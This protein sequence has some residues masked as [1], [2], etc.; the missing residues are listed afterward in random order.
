MSSLCASS[1]SSVWLM[2]YCNIPGT[3][4][5]KEPDKHHDDSNYQQ[6]VNEPSHGVTAHQTQ[7]P[8]NYQYYC[9]CPQ[10]RI[11]LPDCSSSLPRPAGQ[12][13]GSLFGIGLKLPYGHPVLYALHTFY[14]IDEFRDQVLFGR[15]L[16][17]AAYGYHT[18]CRRHRGVECAG[19]TM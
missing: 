16:C 4:P 19:R 14:V 9:N 10:H 1:L 11:L 6:D 17:L 2:T 15:T 8:Q 7:E 13:A 18:A 5:S 12:R 3:A